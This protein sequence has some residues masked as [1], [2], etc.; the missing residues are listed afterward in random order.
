VTIRDAVW[1]GFSRF[2]SLK[3]VTVFFMNLATW[4]D[5]PL[6]RATAGRIRLS[7]VIPTLLLRCTGA[8]SGLLREVPLLYV[9]EGDGALL[10]GSNGGKPYDP[11]WCHNLRGQSR[12]SCLL[13][14][15]EGTFRVQEL[16]GADRDAAWESAVAIYPGYRRYEQRA[17]RTIP[18]FRLI[19]EAESQP[20]ET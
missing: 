10:V 19:P 6:M 3:P 20:R 11:A 15:R 12:V 18:L 7:F 1:R 13:A 9:P 16:G 8:R 5:R 14:G 2:V 17:G 4:V